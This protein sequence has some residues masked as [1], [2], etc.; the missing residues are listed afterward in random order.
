MILITM[1]DVIYISCDSEQELITP[2]TTHEQM[3]D[4]FF[5]SDG[6]FKYY[7]NHLK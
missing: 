1:Y 3:K 4:V 6:N 5:L 2:N 7:K